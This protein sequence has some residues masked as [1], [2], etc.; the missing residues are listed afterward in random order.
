M[1][2]FGSMKVGFFASMACHERASGHEPT[3]CV[4]VVGN[5]QHNTS[6]LKYATYLFTSLS[7]RRPQLFSMVFLFGGLKTF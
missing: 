3:T 1:V 2:W 5:K 4:E 7:V 6:K